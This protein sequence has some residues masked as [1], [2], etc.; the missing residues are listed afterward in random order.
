LENLVFTELNKLGKTL[1][2]YK[3]SRSYECDFLI[4]EEEQVRDAIQVTHKLTR[5]N[6]EREIRGLLSALKA[7]GLTQGVII[8]SGQSEEFRESGFDIRVTPY[9]Q[10]MIQLQ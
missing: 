1:F 4:T 3:D 8:T 6:R 5:E 2:Y 10:W 9:W 7:F